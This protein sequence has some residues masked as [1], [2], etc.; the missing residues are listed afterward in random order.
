MAMIEHANDPNA[1]VR[2]V[3]APHREPTP[4]FLSASLIHPPSSTDPAPPPQAL[5]E[6]LREVGRKQ[7]V[8]VLSSCETY[9]HKHKKVRLPPSSNPCCVVSRCACCNI[10]QPPPA[11]SPPIPPARARPPRLSARADEGSYLRRARPGAGGA[12]VAPGQAR[13]RR[14][15]LQAGATLESRG[16]ATRHGVG[17]VQLPLLVPLPSLAPHH[18]RSTSTTPDRRLCPS[19]RA[20]PLPSLWPWVAP[21]AKLCW[22][23]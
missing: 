11:V 15:D 8:L 2:K 9:L 4:W 21:T 14:D 13:R 1:A 7:P 17:P 10:P 16:A 23:S 19:G 6:S 18:A 22:T 5:H 3:R 20:R 12:R